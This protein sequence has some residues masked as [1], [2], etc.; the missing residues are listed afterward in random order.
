M[1][2]SKRNKV[3]ALTKVK[4]KG[5]AGK[6]ELV[7]KVREAVGEYRNAFV[8]SFENIRSGPFKVIANQWRA[9]SRFF[10]GKNKVIQVALGRTPEEEPADNTH[11]LSKYLRGNVCLL[12]SNKGKEA[13]E[14]RFSEVEASHEDFAT[15]GTKAPYTVFLKQGT[16]ALDGYAH[17]LEPQMQLLGLPVKL[18]FQKIELLSDVYVCREGQTLN[19]EQCKILKILG[20]KMAN[21]KL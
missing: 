10:L 16:E 15:A 2:K 5:R 6:E 3:V 7:D 20:H 1:P 19:V 12:L 4:T 13:I 21:F 9:D 17:S 18:N 11:L 8:V 14:K